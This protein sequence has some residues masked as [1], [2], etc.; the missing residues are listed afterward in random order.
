MNKRA[1]NFLLEDVQVSFGLLRDGETTL[2]IVIMVP[3][4]MAPVY[5][6]NNSKAGTR[7]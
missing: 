2:E 6:V 1:C 7:L 3:V 5:P 4:I